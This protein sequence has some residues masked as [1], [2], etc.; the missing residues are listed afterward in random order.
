M[1]HGTL[2][3]FSSSNYTIELKEDAKPS[4]ATFFPILKHSR[5]NS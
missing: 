4:H 2:G 5:T 1:F 3:K